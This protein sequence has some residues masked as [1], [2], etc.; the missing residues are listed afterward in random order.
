MRVFFLSKRNCYLARV[1]TPVKKVLGIVTWLD[2]SIGVQ[3][4]E[5]HQSV[6]TATHELG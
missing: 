4:L 5:K 1:L 3:N 2:R 6:G